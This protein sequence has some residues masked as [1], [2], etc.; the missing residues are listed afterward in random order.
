M[1][2]DDARLTGV[3][4][5]DDISELARDVAAYHKEVRRA[6]RARRR[7]RLL[8]RRGVVPILVILAATGLASMV[9]VLLTLMAPRTVGHPPAPARLAAPTVP[10]GQV[11]GLLPS[12]TLRAQDGTPVSTRDAT[13]RPVVYALVPPR[14]GCRDLLNTLAGQA[15]SES[16]RLAV[17]VPAASDDATV[18]LVADLDRGRPSVYF[19]RSAALA[20]AVA[21]RGVTVV[22]VAPDG[23]IFDI[24]RGVTN[25]METSV[26][27]SLQSMLLPQPS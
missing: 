27:A 8:A 18:D 14:C 3:V 17:V 20:T 12:A 4:V 2:D 16:L 7:Q 1:P 19:D 22:L 24:E 9:A 13:L 10:A 15:F 6:E 26:A 5:P 23:T 21:S 25:A 11:H